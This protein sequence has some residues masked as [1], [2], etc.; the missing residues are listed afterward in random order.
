MPPADPYELCTRLLYGPGTWFE[1]CRNATGDPG[2][3]DELRRR[4]AAGGDAAA[5]FA[6]RAAWPGTSRLW[7]APTAAPGPAA[8]A[9][10]AATDV[11]AALGG[12]AEPGDLLRGAAAHWRRANVLPEMPLTG[13]DIPAGRDSP[14]AAVR[15]RLAVLADD[16]NGPDAAAFGLLD[17][18]VRA[19]TGEFPRR[20]REAQT[21]VLFDRRSTGGHGT[22][23][24]TLLDGGPPGLYPDPRAMLFLVGDRW[25]AQALDVAWRTAG[26]SLH[27]RCVVWRLTT[28]DTPCDEVTGGSLGAAFGVA[29]T[30]LARRTPPPIRVRRLD[31]RR[32]ITAGLEPDQR[33]S[34]VTGVPNKLEAA[35]RRRLR[36]IL[37]G[38]SDRESIPE[39]LM[40]D[41]RLRFADDLPAAVR[42]SRTRLNPAFVFIMITLM[43]AAAG[44]TGGMLAAVRASRATHQ[45]EIAA[46]LLPAARD[47]RAVDPADALLLEGLATRRGAPGARASLIRSALANRYAGALTGTGLQVPCG[48]SQVWSPDS[49]RVV[50]IRQLPPR[51]VVVWN[52]RDRTVD[53][54]IPVPA[55]VSGCA[56]APDGRTLALAVGDRLH[57]VPAGGTTLPAPVSDVPVQS[58]RYAP[59][60]LLATTAKGEPTRLW[61]VAD[62]RRPRQHAVIITD[63]RGS[64]AALA[65]SRDSRLLAVAEYERVVLADVS[66]PAEPRVVASIPGHAQDL[67]VSSRGILALGLA[68][69]IHLW[70]V[71]D[72][73]RPVRGGTVP[74]RSAFGL[75]TASLGFTPD[76]S[77]L[78]GAADAKS[79]VWQLGAS[80][81]TLVRHLALTNEQVSSADL[82]PD[83]AVALVF[84]GE[85]PTLWRVSGLD[86]PPT[87]G[88]LPLAP[89]RVTGLAAQPGSN[90][91]LVTVA[92]EGASL[93]EVGDPARPVRLG[94]VEP[95]GDS[96]SRSVFDRGATRFA[97][98]SGDGIGVWTVDSG[99]RFRRTGAIPAIGAKG[100]E[101]RAMS[102]DG[103]LLAVVT[104]QDAAPTASA[105]ATASV[106]LWDVR[107][108]PR[109]VSV[110]PAGAQPRII[111]FSP[112]GRTLVTVVASTTVTWWDV[113]DPG[114]PSALATRNLP[115]GEDAAGVIVFAPDG[116]RMYVTGDNG[117]GTVW[118][119]ADP[120]SPV[121]LNTVR[122]DA[123]ANA[124]QAVLAGSALVLAVPGAI[125]IW[126]VADP[127]AAARAVAFD[128]EDENP[129]YFGHAAL[130]RDGLLAATHTADG[131]VGYYNG[132]ALIRLRNLQPILD[133]ITDPIA[134][135]CRIAGHDL[136]RQMWA[137]YAPGLPNS[138]LCPR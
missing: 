138:P 115:A 58:V 45:G 15:R 2:A 101:P 134:A 129:V 36:V 22:L 102:P 5:A 71:G 108:E 137:R 53:T 27:R 100:V 76:G 136:S 32:A 70:D 65:F 85:D 77:R 41:V 90:R 88:T 124:D 96:F 39:P 37:A 99:G 31:R 47:L 84:T 43:V 57:L 109:P 60:G 120:A 86:E 17:L 87:V 61:S 107:A 128:S 93:W 35:V 7:Q 29:L 111:A 75:P 56:F 105:S 54:R 3:T 79:Y 23:R 118:D 9:A 127:R 119:V 130:T 89:A 51:E 78:V 110:L 68:D 4:L 98:A 52:A 6:T 20:R 63:R 46:G 72:P 10:L 73:A 94:A 50:T 44:V 81:P 30:D 74:V 123:D 131:V 16:A 106:S 122:A 26:K 133:V 82:S 40:R 66:R 11:V 112:D 64:A 69:G 34:P 125:D 104:R 25:F 95:T 91:L 92:G 8:S 18:L 21:P 42:L 114:H 19:L 117:P 67:A 38:S 1:L 48:G 33:L 49:T 121:L 83:G 103:A 126:D 59:D 97:V 113:S 55:Q 12:A 13:A 14:Q 116:R 135:A 132:E 24:L 62:P 28:D 80:G